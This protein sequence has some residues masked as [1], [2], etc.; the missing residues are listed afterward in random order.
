MYRSFVLMA[1]TMDILITLSGRFRFFMCGVYFTA[2]F[3]KPKFKTR[4]LLTQGIRQRNLFCPCDDKGCDPIDW[5]TLSGKAE[6][7]K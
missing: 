3:E 6:V 4:S 2:D 7:E 1:P 5:C